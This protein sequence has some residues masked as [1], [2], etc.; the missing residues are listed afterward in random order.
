MGG[1]EKYC[2]GQKPF[3]RHV[4]MATEN[5]SVTMEAW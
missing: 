5:L 1:G 3:G 2:G 4:T